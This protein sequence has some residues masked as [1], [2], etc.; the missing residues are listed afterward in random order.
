VHLEEKKQFRVV[1]MEEDLLLILRNAFPDI[2]EE[3]NIKLVEGE[4]VT[5]DWEEIIS[6]EPLEIIV[7]EKDA[8]VSKASTEE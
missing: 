4:V 1:I 2:P 7:D 3:A 8:V 6:R 5:V